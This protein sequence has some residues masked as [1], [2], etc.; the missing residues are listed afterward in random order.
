MALLVAMVAAVIRA[1]QVDALF[2]SK[3]TLTWLGGICLLTAGLYHD[4]HNRRESGSGAGVN[5]Y[6]TLTEFLRIPSLSLLP[7]LLS[8]WP[9][10]YGVIACLT[11]FTRVMGWQRPFLRW[12]WVLHALFLVTVTAS[13]MIRVLWP[14][15]LNYDWG[16]LGGSFVVLPTLMI[17]LYVGCATPI[18]RSTG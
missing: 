6:G 4:H 7:L 3:E 12:R 16:W 10:V 8:I 5:G 11:S 13:W 17:T 1:D 18:E 14:G 2:S 15:N 9:M